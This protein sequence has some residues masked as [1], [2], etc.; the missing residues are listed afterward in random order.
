MPVYGSRKAKYTNAAHHQRSVLKV[1]LLHSRCQLL[2][3]KVSTNELR[4]K[5][6]G[7]G[8][9]I[10]PGAIQRIHESSGL[11]D[12]SPTLGR[13]APGGIV[14]VAVETTEIQHLCILHD[15]G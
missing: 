12:Q 11:T 14:A 5:A 8:D 1:H 2:F 13:P 6:V 4:C 7:K 15:F 9:K 10:S 3:G